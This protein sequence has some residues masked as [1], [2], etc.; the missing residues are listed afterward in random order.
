[1][2]FR[3]PESNE[4]FSAWFGRLRDILSFAV[5]SPLGFHGLGTGVLLGTHSSP[6]CRQMSHTYPVIG[7]E[8][9]LWGGKEKLGGDLALPDR[10]PHIRL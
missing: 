7:I 5:F 1:M 2:M 9:S 4:I 8:L 6:C 10:V 3:S